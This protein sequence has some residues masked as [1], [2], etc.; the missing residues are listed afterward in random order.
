MSLMMCAGI[1]E[2][3]NK[4]KIHHL[5]SNST[6]IFKLEDLEKRE[7]HGRFGWHILSKIC[8]ISVEDLKGSYLVIMGK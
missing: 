3:F 4:V 1:F 8:E 5:S 2:D 6:Y 7:Y